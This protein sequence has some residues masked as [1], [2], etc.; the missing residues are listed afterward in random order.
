[1]NKFED[2][3][4]IAST[5]RL[6]EPMMGVFM[7]ALV[8][9]SF[10]EQLKLDFSFSRVLSI[11]FALSLFTGIFNSFKVKSNTTLISLFFMTL[12]IGSLKAFEVISVP[13]ETAEF[14]H[15]SY[16]GMFITL[17]FLII[18]NNMGNKNFDTAITYNG[19]LA[20]FCSG[21]NMLEDFG[22]NIP[23]SFNNYIPVFFLMLN[24]LIYAFRSK[25]SS[26]QKSI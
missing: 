21:P 22:Y 12:F 7:L 13:I 16:Y 14:F 18:I 19:F 26:L 1:M 10:I 4:V 2:Q 15:K 25:P 20:I 3:K 6:M 9:R 23:E 11:I 5:E 8:Y 17:T 24:L